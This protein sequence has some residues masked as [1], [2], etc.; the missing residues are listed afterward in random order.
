MFQKFVRADIRL[1]IFLSVTR[2]SC[3]KENGSMFHAKHCHKCVPDVYETNVYK[4]IKIDLF[5]IS[6][7]SLPISTDNSVIVKT[8]NET[9]RT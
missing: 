7:D 1:N 5:V 6:S 4:I 3:L 9:I 2:K 8:P